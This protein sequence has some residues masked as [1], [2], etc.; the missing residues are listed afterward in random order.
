MT[1]P[2]PPP[3]GRVFPATRRTLLEA[4][5]GGGE[6][7]RR[8]HDALVAAYW[9][10]VYKVL[11][12]RFRVP[13]GEAEDLTQDFFLGC[14]EKGFFERYDAGRA[15]F[16]TYLRTCLDGFVGHRREAEGR[17]KRGGGVTHLAVDFASAE[18][19]VARL[20]P[21]PDLDAEELFH[22][23]WVRH[24]F[25]MALERARRSLEER[26]QG[27]AW[28]VFERYDLEGTDDPRR[29]TYSDLASALGIPESRVTNRLAAARR[30]L[31]RAVL[32]V[33]AEVTG[34][35]GELR[36]EARAVLGVDP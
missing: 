17:R 31:R 9:K 6:E 36:D 1:Q 32:E 14:L 16:R 2:P 7:R 26:G 30:E 4:V 20:L 13:A 27:G 15:R 22:R 5:R 24:L 10:P 23:E 34:S 18:D 25:G 8:A 33:L 21:A 29:P 3:G 12:L 28:T 11:R 19:E 35:D